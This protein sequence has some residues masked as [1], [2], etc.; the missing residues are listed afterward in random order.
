MTVE[1]ATAQRGAILQRD[2]GRRQSDWRG[3][4][5]RRAAGGRP[6]AGHLRP[7]RR[8]RDART[9][10]RQDRRLR[11]PASKS[12]RPEAA[13]EVSRAT[14]RQREADLSWP[15]P[16][17]SVRAISSQRQLLPKQTLDDTE[18]RY[19][20][21]HRAARSR[22]GAEHAVEG[23]ARRAAHQSREHDHRLAGQRLRRR[24]AVDP[25]A[26]VGAE[27][28]G[29]RRRRHLPRSPRR[30][31]RREGPESSFRPATTRRSK[32]TRIPARCS[33]AGSPASRRYSTRRHERRRSRSRSRTPTSA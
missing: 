30:Q 20:S 18:A 29:R 12:N 16:T 28:A 9:A 11:D 5:F 32:S 10:H 22:A 23:A 31:R 25:G 21:A 4:G 6:P 7:P 27:R 14:I 24:R 17:S 15:R 19:Q 1:L 13:Q 3:H 33:W 26:F 2:D 8:S